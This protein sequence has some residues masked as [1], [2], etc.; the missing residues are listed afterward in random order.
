MALHRD[1]FVEHY[2]IRV[3]IIVVGVLGFIVILFYSFPRFMQT[4][5][6]IEQDFEEVVETFDIP[7]TQQFQA[8]PP[9]SRPSIPV[10]SEDEDIAEDITIAET[11]LDD[12]EWDAP[13]PPPDAGP[14]SRFVAYD[15]PPEPIGGYKAIQR[16][17]I[18]PDIAREA[19]IE[20]MVIIQAFVDKNGIVRETVVLK[21]IPNTGL[22][23]AA[24][25]AIKRT[26]W[27]PARQRDM[28]VGVWISVP[29][30]F[31]LN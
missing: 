5:E 14:T 28:K 12:F 23:E 3:R 19:G 27:K 29:V 13:P 25:D 30:N 31:K 15:D 6:A 20:G 10:E 4:G 24:A 22:D 17:V 16:N 1:E 26:R 2:P 11:G 8:P 18:Y 21:G 9:P 7:P